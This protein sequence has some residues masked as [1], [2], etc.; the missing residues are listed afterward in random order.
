MLGSGPRPH[1]VQLRSHALLAALWELL[2]W[3]P[4]TAGSQFQ[5]HQHPLQLGSQQ[6]SE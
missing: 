2:W 4:R 1:P 6:Q 3:W 5:G